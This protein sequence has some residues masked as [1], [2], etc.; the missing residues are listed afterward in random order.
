MALHIVFGDS[1]A[2]NLKQFLSNECAED[3]VIA[4]R[5]NLS[6]GP[7]ANLDE[8]E[9]A[10]KR[11]D[12][13]ESMFV[14]NDVIKAHEMI[15]QLD[16]EKKLNKILESDENI[17]WVG[18]NAY[19]ELGL[20]RVCSLLSKEGKNNFIVKFPDF[21]MEFQNGNTFFAKS[22]GSILT[23]HIQKIMKYKKKLSLEEIN[24]YSAKWNEISKVNSLL[25]VRNAE[26]DFNSVK[27][28]YFDKQI[29]SECSKEMQ[30]AA[31]LVGKLVSK[32][33]LD[34]DFILYRIRFLVTKKQLI[35]RG[36]LSSMRLF[37]VKLP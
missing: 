11:F 36:D 6:F 26:F 21:K 14:D 29:L 8:D 12:W 35:T 7:I 1:A 33:A 20:L 10:S 18:P 9:G 37:N 24:E 30:K 28:N 34:V 5:D 16:D 32:Y 17:F 23:N 25:R 31:A 3:K 4:L 2:G 15:E 19:A 27:E 13:L 22:L